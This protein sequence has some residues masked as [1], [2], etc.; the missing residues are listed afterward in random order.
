[1]SEC[2][3]E[4]FKWDRASLLIFAKILVLWIVEMASSSTPVKGSKLS[5]VKLI[6]NKDCDEP[7][8]KWH[9]KVAFKIDES[10]ALSL[11]PP[12]DL[13]VCDIRAFID[14]RIGKVVDYKLQ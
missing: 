2:F 6:R 3:G 8:Y 12:R 13:L 9:P 7:N 14:C 5:K 11:I 10:R 1:M 4:R